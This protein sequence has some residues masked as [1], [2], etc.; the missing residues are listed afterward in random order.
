MKFVSEQAVH[1]F[2]LKLLK[3]EMNR[4]E[5]GHKLFKE[6]LETDRSKFR[7]KVRPEW[8]PSVVSSISLEIGTHSTV[9]Q[10]RQNGKLDKLSERPDR[11]LQNLS[12]SNVIIMD[13]GEL[14]R[15]V[16][17]V[18]LLGSKHPVGNKFNEVNHLLADVDKLVRELR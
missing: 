10:N 14:P 3:Q 2:Q 11:P 18:L 13:G 17:D 6:I 15:Y 16:L 1:S 5:I 12:H 9:N 8:M 7:E 4:A